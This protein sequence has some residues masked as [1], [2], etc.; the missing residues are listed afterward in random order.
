MTTE[1]GSDS[2]SWNFSALDV[3][4]FPPWFT[5]CKLTSLI[6]ALQPTAV[7]GASFFASPLRMDAQSMLPQLKLKPLSE[8]PAK[9]SLLKSAVILSTKKPTS[10]KFLRI[11]IFSSCQKHFVFT[12]IAPVNDLYTRQAPNFII[13]SPFQSD[14]TAPFATV[15][16]AWPWEIPFG[17]VSRAH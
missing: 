10:K 7:D 4:A 17:L 9:L 3:P 5:H 16:Q 14:L 1:I 6:L 12:P 13:F 15:M 2:V 8:T 11:M